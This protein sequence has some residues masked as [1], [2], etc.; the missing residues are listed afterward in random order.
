MV[1]ALGKLT[2]FAHR[3]FSVA[4]YLYNSET[5][6]NSYLTIETR[7]WRE[8]TLQLLGHDCLIAACEF[9]T[10]GKEVIPYIPTPPG[11]LAA[12]RNSAHANIDGARA[13]NAAQATATVIAARTSDIC[14]FNIRVAHAFFVEGKSKLGYRVWTEGWTVALVGSATTT[15]WRLKEH[16][17]VHFR[18]SI[19]Y[20]EQMTKPEPYGHRMLSINHLDVQKPAPQL[21]TTWDDEHTIADI[22]ILQNYKL[23]KGINNYPV[24]LIYDPKQDDPDIW[25]ERSYSLP[26]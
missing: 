22:V 20:F 7:Q 9:F 15:F 21:W 14:K 5:D 24:T 11:T 17:G 4:N 1:T 8:Q 6:F 12:L 2:S 10:N 26:R 19:P 13:I 18:Q 16:S 25:T 3:S 23:P